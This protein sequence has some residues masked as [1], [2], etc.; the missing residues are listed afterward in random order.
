MTDYQLTYFRERNVDNL[1]IDERSSDF[2]YKC[3]ELR[4]FIRMPEFE[5]TS[6]GPASAGQSSAVEGP[7]RAT[8]IIKVSKVRK[9]KSDVREIDVES[10]EEASTPPASLTADESSF[11]NQHPSEPEVATDTQQAAS[12]EERGTNKVG[13]SKPNAKLRR[14]KYTK[15][16]WLDHHNGSPHFTIP[17]RSNQTK[18]RASKRS[19]WGVQ[20]NPST[21]LICRRWGLW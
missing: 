6:A 7:P 1:H 12:T 8:P 4:P 17:N 16:R 3:T 2:F 20:T 15:R 21:L 5:L 19:H 13:S 14:R 10:D 9:R 11:S 18:V